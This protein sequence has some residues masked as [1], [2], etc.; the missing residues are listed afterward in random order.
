MVL[1][2][3]GFDAYVQMTFVDAMV[4]YVVVLLYSPRMPLCQSKSGC[5]RPCPDCLLT[6]SMLLT[7]CASCL[8]VGARPPS[9]LSEP[10]GARGRLRAAR[11]PR[12]AV[13]GCGQVDFEA[14]Y[15]FLS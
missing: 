9:S 5:L 7:G 8:K 3:A 12:A 13:C 11:R 6:P 14:L 10:S 2:R 1:A 4:C 15:Y